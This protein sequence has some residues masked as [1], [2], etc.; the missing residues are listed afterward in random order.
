MAK[1]ELY[2]QLRTGQ[3]TVATAGTAVQLSATST[4]ARRLKIKALAANAG[5]VYVGDVDVSATTGWQLAAGEEITLDDNSSANRG[6]EKEFDLSTHYADAATN[7]DKVM[8]T[9]LGV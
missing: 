7:G 5:V 9:Y 4:I 2:T 6:Q 8:F 3:A 1:S